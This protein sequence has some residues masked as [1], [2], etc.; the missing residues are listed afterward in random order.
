[1]EKRPLRFRVRQFDPVIVMDS[2]EDLLKVDR[3]IYKDE[4]NRLDIKKAK[5]WWG[6][7]PNIFSILIDSN[8]RI[9]GY[10]IFAPVKDSLI[11]KIITDKMDLWSRHKIT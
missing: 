9:H 11:D 8:G 6:I 5:E 1:M 10:T 7:N 3:K 4:R 2:F